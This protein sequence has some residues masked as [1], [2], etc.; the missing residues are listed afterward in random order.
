[1]ENPTLFGFIDSLKTEQTKRP[2][3]P[4]FAGMMT[5]EFPLDRHPGE[6]RGP[7]IFYF[8]ILPQKRLDTQ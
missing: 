7:E 2:R 4:A 1:V 8:P 6:S 5:G 3:I